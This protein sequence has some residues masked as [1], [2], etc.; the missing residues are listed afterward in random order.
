MMSQAT[1]V[2]VFTAY[3]RVDK[4]VKP[5]PTVFPEDAKVKRQ[6]PEDPLDSL[7]NLPSHPPVFIPTQRLT[8]ENVKLLNIDSNDFL[9]PEEKK[10]FLYIMS[11]NERTL[12]FDET[13]RGTLRDDYFSP[14][15]IPVIPHTPWEHHNIP[16][17]PAL[18]DQVIALLKEKI[19]AGVYEPS[20]S[21]YRSR[22]FTVLKKNGTL[23]IVHDLQ[24]LNSV[25]VREAGLPPVLESFVEPFAGCQC[26]TLF[27]MYWGFDARKVH[28]SSRD[29]TSFLTPLGLLHIT[30]MPMRFTNSLAEFQ[31]HMMFIL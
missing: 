31:A 28:P 15:I 13:Q 20:Q 1:K 25:T 3:K 6:F 16:I 21:S 8:T 26:Y 23:R 11:V 27:D 9:W 4:K 24:A 19:K 14:Y 18:R 30:S 10:L 12:A 29:L 2:N 22:W 7:P 17:P 5:V